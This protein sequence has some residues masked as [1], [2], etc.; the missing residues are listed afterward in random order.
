MSGICTKNVYSL[1]AI[2]RF[3]VLLY[4]QAHA[5]MSIWQRKGRSLEESPPT[6]AACEEMYLPG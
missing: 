6:R 2:E 4:N 3:V 1:S 5:L